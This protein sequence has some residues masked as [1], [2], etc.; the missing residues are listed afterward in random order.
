MPGFFE[1]LGSGIASL[2]GSGASAA[3]SAKM[4]AQNRQFQERMTRHRYQY[5]MEDM[6]KA[7]LNPILAFGQ[8]PPSAPSGAMGKTPDFGQSITQ[9]VS[10]F[11]QRALQRQQAQTEKDRQTN[12]QFDSAFK[13]NQAA[14]SGFMAQLA[15][16]DLKKFEND[17]LAWY[18]TKSQGPASAGIGVAAKGISTMGKAIRNWMKK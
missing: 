9:G 11:A 16:Y 3:V 17:P 13:A 1:G 5:Q 15:Q 7:G 8:Q 6:R 4:A 2:F 14:H 10:A 12:L 18:L